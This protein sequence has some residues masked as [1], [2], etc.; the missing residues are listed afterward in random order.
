M[1]PRI[2]LIGP[3]GAGKSTIGAELARRF[4]FDHKDTDQLIEKLAEKTISEMFIE[5]GEE[6]FRAKEKEVLREVLLGESCVLS[7]GGGACIS[8]DSQSA[9]RASG[10][11]IVYLKISL[12]H[13]AERIG[14]NR[15]RPLLLSSP[16]AQWQALMNERAPIYESL[17]DVIINVDEKPV[18]LVCDEIEVAYEL[19]RKGAGI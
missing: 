13:V 7:L 9:V 15:D 5:D 16:R 14:F 4:K 1:A 3:M 10:S 19:H 12:A 2:I 18:P 8:P 6:Y 17:A 11:F